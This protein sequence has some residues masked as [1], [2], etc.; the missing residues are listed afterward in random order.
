MLDML[1]RYITGLPRSGEGG[2]EGGGG[3]SGGLSL[4]GPPVAYFHRVVVRAAT[5]QISLEAKVNSIRNMPAPIAPKYCSRDGTYTWA[6][7]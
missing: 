2:G 7:N 5:A 4:M 6:W 1:D 3:E